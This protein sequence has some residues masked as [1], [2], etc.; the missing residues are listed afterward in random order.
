M[1]A[2]LPHYDPP[3]I[4]QP[5]PTIEVKRK[6]RRSYSR[7]YDYSYRYTNR[8]PTWVY[9]GMVFMVIGSDGNEY[10]CTVIA[11]DEETGTYRCAEYIP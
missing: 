3:A 2:V 7:K 8:L 10:Q 9:V 1:M 11:I 4:V 5:A 6:K